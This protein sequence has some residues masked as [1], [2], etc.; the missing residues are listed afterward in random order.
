MVCI[1]AHVLNHILPTHI[2]MYVERERTQSYLLDIWYVCRKRMYRLERECTEYMH[3]YTCQDT[4]I[5][6]C[7]CVTGLLHT[8]DNESCTCVRWPRYAHRVLQRYIFIDG[9]SF[10]FRR[11]SISFP[12]LFRTH[13]HVCLYIILSPYSFI[14]T[15][16]ENL[17]IQSSVHTCI[18][19]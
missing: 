12:S 2:C 1:Y 19:M 13:T 16:R 14:F 8:C 9:Y 17:H 7:M 3:S 11:I 6:S 10:L 4:F 5:I 15:K 18:H